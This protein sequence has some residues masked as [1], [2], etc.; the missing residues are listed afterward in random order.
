M[1]YIKEN[2]DI[3]EDLCNILLESDT[4]LSTTY[5]LKIFN[6]ICIHFKSEG[7]EMI[8][9]ALS[10]SMKDDL[11]SIYKIL[12]ESINNQNIDTKTNSIEFVC[13]L[14][15]YSDKEKVITYKIES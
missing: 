14:V 7:I 12:N 5:V 15:R 2:Q 3:L 8:Y 1:E 10:S 11:S 13:N 4:M 6:M 9:K